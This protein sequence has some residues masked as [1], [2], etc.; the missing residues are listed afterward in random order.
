[1]WA[2]LVDFDGTIVT[3]DIAERALSRFA[4]PGWEKFNELLAGGEISVDECVRQEYGMIRARSEKEITDYLRSH[5]HLRPGFRN[6]IQ[7]CSSRKLE[8]AIVS[9]GLD[10]CIKD[11][12]ETFGITLPR[13]ICPK[14]RFTPQGTIRLTF[15][16]YRWPDSRDF[17]EDAVFSYKD[18]G[19][20]V[21][22]VGDGAGDVH[23]AEASDRVFAIEGSTLQAMC[24]DRGVSHR[25]VKTF[26][27]IMRRLDGVEP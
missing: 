18:S 10:F 16:R 20:R 13:L 5:Y 1:M 26:A 22:Y 12:F 4:T 25:A 2:L 11:A 23:A 3:E 15:P 24:R 9:A 27:P 7:E 14:S 8:F 19:F 17:K 21:A 6:L